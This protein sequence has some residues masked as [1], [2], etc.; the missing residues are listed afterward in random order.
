MSTVGDGWIDRDAARLRTRIAHRH[1]R[2]RCRRDLQRLVSWP[3]T[4]DYT[5]PRVRTAWRGAII[6]RGYRDLTLALTGRPPG[7]S[8]RRGHRDYFRRA[9]ISPS[10]SW[11]SRRARRGPATAVRRL[12]GAQTPGLLDGEL[13][14]HGPRRSSMPAARRSSVIG[15]AAG[16][17]WTSVQHRTRRF[18]RR[19]AAPRGRPCGRWLPRTDPTAGCGWRLHQSGYPHARPAGHGGWV[20][21]SRTAVTLRTRPGAHPIPLC[22]RC[23]R[24]TILRMG[25]DS[26]CRRSARGSER[27]PSVATVGHRSRP[28]RR[29]G[30][31]ALTG[32]SARCC[33]VVA[34]LFMVPAVADQVVLRGRQSAL[35]G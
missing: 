5:D 12:A 26:A 20:P 7:G 28:V 21:H 16:P 34:D 15:E 27:S 9:P 8:H 2:H 35:A 17:T 14:T 29:D 24:S 13:L 30:R 23:L 4:A 1:R 25:D 32:E 22:V 6:R 3:V 33:T 11:G 18:P 19:L 31:P 10:G